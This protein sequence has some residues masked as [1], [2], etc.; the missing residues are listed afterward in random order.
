MNDPSLTI[1][2]FCAAEKTSRSQLYEDWKNGTGPDF[3]Y[4]GSHRR[5]SEEARKRWRHA[6][7][8]QAKQPETRLKEAAASERA[9]VRCMGAS[10]A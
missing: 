3:F 5:I 9:R 7:E 1:N 2:E 6:R 8:A 10:H 4:V